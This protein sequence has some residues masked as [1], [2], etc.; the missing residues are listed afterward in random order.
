M[1]RIGGIEASPDVATLEVTRAYLALPASFRRQAARLE[2]GELVLEGETTEVELEGQEFALF[3]GIRSADDAGRLAARYGLLG[4]RW[5]LGRVPEDAPD[6]P[7]WAQLLGHCQVDDWTREPVHAW[8]RTAGL[9]EFTY[10]LLGLLRDTKKRQAFLATARKWAPP[11]QP[12]PMVEVL[13][14]QSRLYEGKHWAVRAVLDG[15]ARAGLRFSRIEYDNDSWWA[16]F[17]PVDAATTSELTGFGVRVAPGGDGLAEALA[18]LLRPHL[19]QV[20]AS[21]GAQ[22]GRLVPMQST[23]TDLFSILWLQLANAALS[24]VGPRRCAWERCPGPPERPGVFLWRFGRTATGTKHVDSM[25]CHPL[26]QHAA[27]VAKQRARKK[28]GNNGS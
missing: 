18:T 27:A 24:G 5:S 21:V 19:E 10:G 13:E 16:S 1:S 15:A 12:M 11:S 22:G 26:C 8:V 23:P 17:V 3:R 20:R 6:R 7:L 2:G 9:L 14:A 28:E 4:L 25:Y